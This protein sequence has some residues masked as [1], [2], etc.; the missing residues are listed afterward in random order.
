QAAVHQESSGK[1]NED[2]IVAQVG[3][4][5]LAAQ[6]TTANT[7]AFGLLELA[8]HP[9]FQEALRAEIRSVLGTSVGTV[10]YDSMPLLNALIKETIRFYPA[11]PV[12]DR[13]AMQDTAIPLGEAI[14]TITGERIS[15]IPIMKGQL[16][17]IAIASYQRLESRWGTDAHDF[18]PSRW[19]DGTVTQGTAIG[20]YANLLSFSGGPRSCLG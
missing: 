1:L 15:R 19:L 8:R 3:N 6:E 20:P 16:V 17:T 2:E 9:H 11:V 12:S 14:T 13:V 7:I 18:N 10:S 5:M 4:L